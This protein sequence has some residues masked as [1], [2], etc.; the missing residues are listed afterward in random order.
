[1]LKLLAK[2]LFRIHGW[3]VK[4]AIPDDLKKAVIIAAPHTSF[5]DFYYAR[6]AFFI[7]GISLKVTIKKEVVNHPIFGWIIRGLGAIAIDRTP[8]QGNLKKNRSMVDAMV[9]LIKE[10]D[11]LIMM[12]TPEGTRKFVKRWK[13]GFYRVAEQAKIPIILGYLDYAKKHAGVGP[14]FYPTGDYDK[15][16]EEIMDF[17]RT[18]TGK[19]PEK[20][21]K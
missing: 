3:T 14:V 21:V 17:Y 13:S 11:E 9:D 2:F 6:I 7:M 16:V 19:Y 18:K 1:M 5:W 10:R 20:G 12:I 15:D 8:K 4:G